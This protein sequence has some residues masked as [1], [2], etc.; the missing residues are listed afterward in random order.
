MLACVCVVCIWNLLLAKIKV[1]MLSWM[2]ILM[3]KQNNKFWNKMHTSE[4]KQL[5][6]RCNI[7]HRITMAYLY[8][9]HVYTESGKFCCLNSSVFSLFGFPFDF[10]LLHRFKMQFMKNSHKDRALCSVLSHAQK[11]NWKAFVCI[12]GLEYYLGMWMYV[13]FH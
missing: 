11:V 3:A 10:I 1:V 2:R 7:E 13:L 9:D 5:I 8:I 12:F 4:R 6:L